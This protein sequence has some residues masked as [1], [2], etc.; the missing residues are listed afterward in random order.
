MERENTFYEELNITSY[1]TQGELNER[2]SERIEQAE[3]RINNTKK[4]INDAFHTLKNKSTKEAYDRGLIH[5]YNQAKQHLEEIEQEK[6]KKFDKE[7][8]EVCTVVIIVAIGV[9]ITLTIIGI[10]FL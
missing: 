4:D 2:Y 5:G 8:A 3:E 6:F 9:A 1:T 7:I 10:S